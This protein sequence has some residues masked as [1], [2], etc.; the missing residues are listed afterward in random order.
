MP[1]GY[2]KVGYRS[3]GRN[4]SH[5][6]KEFVKHITSPETIG[7]RPSAII[8]AGYN[9]KNRYNASQ[10]ATQMLK[11]PKIRKAIDKALTK[12][13]LNESYVADTLYDIIEEGKGRKVTATDALK[14]LDMTLKLKDAYP[15]SRVESVKLD[16]RAELQGKTIDELKERLRELRGEREVLEGEYEEENS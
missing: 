12:A 16:L 11:K 5:K 13:G 7:D 10:M 3:K 9:V 15:S 4:L 2:P 8:K 6:E 1:K 14:G